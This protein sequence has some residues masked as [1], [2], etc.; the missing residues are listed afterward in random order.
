MPPSES[1]RSTVSPSET[2]LRSLTVMCRVILSRI[3]R[4]AAI[5]SLPYQEP[6]TLSVSE[7]DLRSLAAMCC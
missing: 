1:F 7:M 6:S 4:G 3:N 2:S 5:M